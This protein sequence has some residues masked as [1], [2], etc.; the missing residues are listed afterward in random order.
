MRKQISGIIA[1]AGLAGALALGAGPAG[2]S[3][4]GCNHPSGWPPQS[5]NEI[6]IEHKYW[7]PTQDYERHYDRVGTSNV[8]KHSRYTYCGH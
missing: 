8:F 5:H 2:A 4:G 7:Q 1:V 6:F 3:S